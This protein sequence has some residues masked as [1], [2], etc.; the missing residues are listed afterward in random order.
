MKSRCLLV[1]N[2]DDTV[3]TAIRGVDAI[4]PLGSG[5]PGSHKNLAVG[6]SRYRTPQKFY[7]KCSV[8]NVVLYKVLSILQLF[9]LQNA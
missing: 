3:T 5:G 8:I 2:D 1:R 7:A 9:V 6:S 4:G